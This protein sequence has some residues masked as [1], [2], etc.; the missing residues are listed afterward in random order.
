[1]VDPQ[2][3]KK[4]AAR[5]AYSASFCRRLSRLAELI[6]V[7]EFG[8]EVVSEWMVTTCTAAGAAVG[9]GTSG[10]DKEVVSGLSIEGLSVSVA[11]GPVIPLIC[12]TFAEWAHLALS[13]ESSRSGD[14]M[15]IESSFAFPLP[16]PLLYDDLS[17]PLFADA[18][19]A[20]FSTCFQDSE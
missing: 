10:G 20:L 7:V 8:P 5:A 17:L 4:L 16:L 13:S 12:I 1:V 6:G 2:R 11:V 3:V 9:E 18:D 19:L 15:W 14:R